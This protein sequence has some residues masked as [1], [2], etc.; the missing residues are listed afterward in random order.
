MP[1]LSTRLRVAPALALTFLATAL[2]GCGPSNLVR[3]V[4]NPLS[5][6]ICGLIVIVLDIVA[7]VEVWKSE[8][9]DTDKLIWTGVI[10]ILPF[11]GMIAYYLFG[12]K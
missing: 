7:L 8:R 2:S 4:T 9:S 5:F 6:G 1:T 3:G 10:V 11:V 12:R